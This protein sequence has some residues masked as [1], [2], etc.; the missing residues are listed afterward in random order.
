MA[1]VA[2]VDLR[3]GRTNV[4]ADLGEDAVGALDDTVVDG[5]GVTVV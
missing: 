5:A 1:Q 4:G 3:V 2:V